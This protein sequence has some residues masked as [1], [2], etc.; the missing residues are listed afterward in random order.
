MQ[1]WEFFAKT[2]DNVNNELIIDKDL[3]KLDIHIL[4]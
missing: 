2:F 4:I 1:D 3:L